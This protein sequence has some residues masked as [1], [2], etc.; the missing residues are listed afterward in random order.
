MFQKEEHQSLHINPS[1][2]SA[3][4]N[5]CVRIMNPRSPAES[6]REETKESSV[7]SYSCPAF[8]ILDKSLEL[9]LK[10]Q[11]DHDL[12]SKCIAGLCIKSSD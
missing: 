10:T 9:T 11:K 12:L 7:I 1:Q 2:L 5:V 8:G 3:S 6:N 4:G